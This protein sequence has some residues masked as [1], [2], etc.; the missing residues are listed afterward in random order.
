M[1]LAS[2]VPCLVVSA[3]LAGAAGATPRP[4]PGDWRHVAEAQERLAVA[5]HAAAEALLARVPAQSEAARDAAILRGQLDAALA[6]RLDLETGAFLDTQPLDRWSQRAGL[7]FWPIA[8]LELRV[9]ALGLWY[10]RAADATPATATTAAVGG[11]VGL[12]FRPAWADLDVGATGLARVWADGSAQVSGS[13][14]IEGRWL[15]PLRLRASVRRDELLDSHAA[16]REHAFVSTAGG[17]LAVVDWKG[18]SGEL[19]GEGRWYSDGNDGATAYGWAVAPLLR[20]ALTLQA[21]WGAAWADTSRSRWSLTTRTYAPYFTPLSVRRHGPIVVAALSLG[22]LRFDASGDVAVQG[23][24]LDPTALAWGVET[25]VGSTH[26]DLRAGVSL[27]L[28]GARLGVTYHHNHQ[29][30][31]RFHDAALRLELPL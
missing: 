12:L 14:E 18:W 8:S 6:P 13:G 28:G 16:T 27:D 26:V 11:R 9:H 15:S 30:Y 22:K 29:T 31:Y 10:P 21:G 2:F 25:R 19:R 4:L 20:G 5:D 3:A 1:H 23:S 7:S 24:E 17:G